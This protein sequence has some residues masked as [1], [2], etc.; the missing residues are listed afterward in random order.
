MAPLEQQR[1]AMVAST[2]DENDSVIYEAL[3][4]PQH[5]LLSRRVDAWNTTSPEMTKRRMEIIAVRGIHYVE[6]ALGKPSQMVRLAVSLNS[7]YTVIPCSQ[8]V[9]IKLNLN[10]AFVS[11]KLSLLIDKH[12][13]LFPRMMQPF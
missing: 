5:E 8:L 9:R 11:S 1:S 13:I 6:F 4:L 3:H 12:P 10:L 7:A 2:D